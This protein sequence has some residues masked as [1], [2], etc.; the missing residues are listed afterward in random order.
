MN[1]RIALIVAIKEEN[2]IRRN[3]IASMDS[4]AAHV[5]LNSVMGIAMEMVNV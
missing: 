5:R 2:A 4:Q 1:I 3:A